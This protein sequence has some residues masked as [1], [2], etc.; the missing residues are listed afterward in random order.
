L[1]REELRTVRSCREENVQY[2][3]YL[4][5]K[6]TGGLVFRQTSVNDAYNEFLCQIQKFS[7]PCLF[8]SLNIRD[9]VSHKKIT[10]RINSYILKFT[11]LEH[12]RRAPER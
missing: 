6:E 3:N 12:T 11:F 8:P 5:E 7:V 2:L 4:L 9:Q 1:S 10:G